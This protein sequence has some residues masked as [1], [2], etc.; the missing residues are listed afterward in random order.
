MRKLRLQGLEWNDPLEEALRHK[1]IP[2]CN[3]LEQISEITIPRCLLKNLEKQEVLLYVFSGASN[4]AYAA[5]KYLEV[6]YKNGESSRRL[7]AAKTNVAPLEA[8]STPRQQY[9]P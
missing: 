9:W 6:K 2:W 3:E 7:A 4:E 5:V 8:T 1:F